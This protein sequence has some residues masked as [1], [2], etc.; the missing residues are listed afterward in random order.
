MNIYQFIK[1]SDTASIEEFIPKEMECTVFCFDLEDSIQDTL[2]P[3]NTR[4]LK[5]YHRAIL[6]LILKKISIQS[7]RMAVGVRI[8]DAH[9]K[10]YALDIEALAGAGPISSVFLPKAI[11]AEQVM[12]LQNRLE[13]AGVHY[14]EI[15]PVIET[16]NGLHNLESIL[17]L[18]SDK[19]KSIAFGHCD[20]NLDNDIYPFIHQDARE[21][22]NWVIRIFN[23]IR[24]YQLSFVNS[25][26][27]QLE[28]D[29]RFNDM[30]ALLY[31]VCQGQFGQI[32]LTAR[33]THLCRS[34]IPDHS[35]IITEKVAN[36]LN[37][38]VQ[39]SY[40]YDF[41]NLY[42]GSE[43][44][45][46]FAITRDRVILSPHEYHASHHHILKSHLP[47]I[48]FTFVGGCF[49]VKGNVLFENRFHQLIKM[50]V[51]NKCAVNFN[52]N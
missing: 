44:R 26:F 3:F 2:D 43:K 42:H 13:L 11:H 30:L 36:P 50:G 27:L 6:K 15:I 10:D 25:P 7:N 29:A 9:T 8:N 12:D 17:N 47:Q 52:V 19:I 16:K 32:T 14:T 31:S 49:P 41:I 45:N 48:H 51:E 5:S 21:Y 1:Y 38:S 24:P 40:A 35:K 46:G 4:A 22:W 33:Q 18:K 28:N 20:Y 39:G 34:F 23:R 37:L